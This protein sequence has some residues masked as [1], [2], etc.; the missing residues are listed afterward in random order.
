MFHFQHKRD[1]VY[2]EILLPEGA[3]LKFKNSSVLWNAAEHAERRVD[4][5]VAKEAVVALP[6]DKEIRLEDRIELSHRIAKEFFLSKGLAVQIDIHAPHD[7]DKNW[8]VHMLAT[9]RRFSEDGKSL[10]AYKARDTDP[11]I[12]KGFVTEAELVGEKVRDIQNAYFKEKGLDLRVD[13]I[14]IVPQEHLGPVRMRHHMNDALKRSELIKETNEALAKDPAVILEALG[15][16]KA[17]LSKQ[18]IERFIFKHVPRA[19]QA[20]LLKGVLSDKNLITL[21]DSSTGEETGLYTLKETR[22][23]EEKLLRFAT[24]L[25]KQESVPLLD[26][27]RNQVTEKYILSLEQQ[28][29]YDCVTQ[30]P[31]NLSIIQGRAGVGKSYVLRPIR[32]V[33]E[34]SGYRVI[35]LAPT[36]KVAQDMLE[37]GFREATTCHAFL[38]AS[39]N[40][41][42]TIDEKTLLIV[43]EAAMLSTELQIELFN[44]AKRAGSK[45]LLVGDSR[46]LSSIQKGGMFE[47]LVEKF[48]SVE[49]T[50]VRRQEI[51]WQRAVSESLSRGEVKEAVHILNDHERIFFSGTKETSCAALINAWSKDH[52]DD[53]HINKLILAQRNVDVDALN[54]AVRDIRRARGELGDHDYEIMTKRGPQRFAEGDRIQLTETDKTQN[55]FNGNFGAIK[56]ITETACTILQDNGQEV[57][58][59]PE[60]YIGLRHGYAGTI[61]KA[62]GSTLPNIYVL[63]DKAT[64]LNNSYVSLTRQTKDLKVFISQTETPTLDHLIQQMGRDHGKEASLKYL[65]LEEVRERDKSL[66]LTQAIQEALKDIKTKV[67]DHFHRNEDFYKFERTQET[68]IH[69]VAPQDPLFPIEEKKFEEVSQLLERRL[70]GLFKE[71]HN[72][73]PDGDEKKFLEK[74][75]SR[76]GEYLFHLKHYEHREPTLGDVKV[77]STRVRFEL[78]RSETIKAEML[79]NLDKKQDLV[80]EDYLRATLY[81]ERLARIE[82]RMFEEE[83]RQNGDVKNPQKFM[84]PASVELQQYQQS[85][86]HLA[87]QLVQEKNLSP[88][89]AT[90]VANEIQRAHESLGKTP[91][92]KTIEVYIKLG[93]YLEERQETLKQTY[94]DLT[95]YKAERSIEYIRR[96]EAEVWLK[97]VFYNKEEPNKVRVHEIQKDA[98]SATKYALKEAQKGFCKDRGLEL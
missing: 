38:F 87:D 37:D 46:Q 69:R 27:V 8:H 88:F 33:H 39:K 98:E 81:A 84:K 17:V 80:K 13:P 86:K 61:Y 60:T 71:K 19:D 65:T 82:G 49:I 43:D 76:T 12:R 4:S 83:F 75:A 68:K 50:D 53:P 41:R 29:A 31:H 32:E 30:I 94:K 97:E 9:T 3:D 92:D 42:N 51:D 11:T 89:V 45:V 95:P 16:N 22:T 25:H 24:S 70:Y 96:S 57:T 56:K 63:H 90:R 66:S 54:C 6:D 79:E 58:F 10:N 44:G 73:F 67:K 14:G 15:K 74:Q 40:Q 55:L 1:N 78:G 20:I 35:G 28:A 48:C 34:A 5:Q 93:S 77:L 62:Q 23:L 59:N 7:E 36:H 47:V 26:S 91:D 64:N 72:R 52:A 85:Q 2:H 21:Y 18:D